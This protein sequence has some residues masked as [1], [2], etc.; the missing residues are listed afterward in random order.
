[1]TAAPNAQG[2]TP[3]EIAS[4]M[5]LGPDGRGAPPEASTGSARRAFEEPIREALRRP[6]CA[7]A[8]SGGRDSS[9][10]LAVATDLAR[11]E[12]L[13][14]PIPV[15]LA[16]PAKPATDESSW[17]R[18][19][20][21]WLRLADW[22]RLEFGDELDI[23]GPVAARVLR[24]H[25]VLHPA[26]AHFL[27]PAVDDA[28]GGSLLTG[29]GGDEI[30]STWAV[31]RLLEPLRRQRRPRAGDLRRLAL[32]S[33]PRRP[34]ER[35]VARFAQTGVTWLRPEVAAEAQR[36][37]AIEYSAEPR[38]WRTRMPWLV[39]RRWAELGLEATRLIGADRDVA[40]H[41]PFLDDRFIAALASA[42]GPFGPPSRRAAMRD[43]FGDVLP[44]SLLERRDKTYLREAFATATVREFAAGFDGMGLDRSLVDEAAL[45]AAWRE[46]SGLLASASLV[47]SLW[48]A[49]QLA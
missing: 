26:N 15:T 40:V 10:V 36:S 39:R 24:R 2:L 12:G 31:G 29:W 49:A 25:G 38:V 42:Y 41:E 34:R 33:L 8:F 4:G 47:Q 13:E 23:V 9:A 17:Q 48:L 16:F 21:A 46:D 28:A 19:V 45:R 30:F 20:I 35:V 43:L 1:M 27:A 32:W 18:E 22:R 37:W 14:P 5:A 11:R 3:L 44:P 7:V 6:P